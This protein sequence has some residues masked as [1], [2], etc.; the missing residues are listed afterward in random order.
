VNSLYGVCE[1]V[2]WN[3]LARPRVPAGSD[4]ENASCQLSAQFREIRRQVAR[5]KAVVGWIK[6]QRLSAGGLV[7]SQNVEAG[8]Q[9]RMRRRFFPF[10]ES[11]CILVP[12][13]LRAG[14][15]FRPATRCRFQKNPGINRDAN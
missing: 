15:W 4:L 6:A 8:N 14:F 5:F 7:E 2:S 13:A 10:I 3:S 12:V 11:P 1:G 9:I